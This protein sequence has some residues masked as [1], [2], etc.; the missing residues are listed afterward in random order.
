[1]LKTIALLLFVSSSYAG[2]ETIFQEPDQKIVL[3]TQQILLDRFPSAFNPSLL[4]LDPGFL[5]IFRYCPD[6]SNQPWLSQIRIVQL[7]ASFEPGTEPQLLNTR[8]RKS[9]TPSQAEDAR[10]F[11]YRD[12]IFLI[13]NDNIDEIFFDQSKRRDLFIAE[14]SF[15]EG[16][17]QLSSPLKLFFEEKYHSQSQQKNWVPFEWQNN[18]FFSYSIHPHQVLSANLKNGSCYSL[19]KTNPPIQWPY[20]SLRGSSQAQ[21]VDGQYLAFFHSSAK[22]RSP[23]SYDWK[24]WHYFMGAY[25]FSAEPPFTLTR[26][27]PKPIMAE[28]F[29]TPSYREKRVVFPGGFVVDGAYIYVAYGKD[30]CEMWIATLDKEALKQAM[31][32]I[33]F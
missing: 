18:L 32:P 8:A 29:Y 15:A 26:M 27:T 4:K 2:T 13:Y 12:K 11:T 1:M 14:L 16:H 5:L 33:G 10:F 31:I 25:T 3:S 9:K 20:G 23:A 19:H 7:D 21:L 22:T 28:E 17:Y 30:D 6:L 24:L